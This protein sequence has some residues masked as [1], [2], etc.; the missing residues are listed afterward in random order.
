MG[1]KQVHDANIVAT[2]LANGVTPLLTFNAADFRRFGSR[3]ELVT[4]DAVPPALIAPASLDH[5]R[6]TTFT[7]AQADNGLAARMP[8][9]SVTKRSPVAWSV[10]SS[11]M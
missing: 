1:G 2:M 11:S 5:W 7:H 10:S 9:G 8:P 6:T 4:P 3:I